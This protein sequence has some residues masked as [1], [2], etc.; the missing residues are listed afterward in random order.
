MSRSSIFSIPSYDK[1]N[2]SITLARIALSL[3]VLFGHSVFWYDYY[4]NDVNPI[5]RSINLCLYKIFQGSG[6]TNLAVIAFITISGYCIHRQGMRL[7][8]WDIKLFL[9]RRF[10]RIYPVLLMATIF[11][12]VVYYYLSADPKIVTITFTQHISLSALIYKLSGLF[13]FIPNN[14]K[15]LVYLGNGALMTCCVEFWLYIFYPFLGLMVLKWGSKVLWTLI[16]SITLMGVIAY[17]LNPELS[18]WWHNGSFFGFL[19]YW[20]IGVYAV[21]RDS[22]IFTYSK[23]I[24]CIYVA[25]TFLLVLHPKLFLLVEMRKIL[26]S[27]LIGAGMQWLETKQI[28]RLPARS[29]FESGYSLYALHTPLICLA[30]VYNF[31]FYVMVLCIL[32]IAYISYVSFERPLSNFGRTI[33]LQLPTHGDAVVR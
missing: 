29:V 17:T 12:A 14:F 2:G 21:S 27:L 4:F 20:W 15:D 25:L 6:E 23:Q 28:P 18:D 1:Y 16:G 30:L 13:A 22:K 5:L 11:S 9:Q 33:G 7:A 10:F 26:F 3:Y 31:N 19:I 8:E 24:I 32:M